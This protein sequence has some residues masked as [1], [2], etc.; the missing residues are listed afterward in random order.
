MGKSDRGDVHI[1][2]P[3]AKIGELLKI[4]N[5]TSDSDIAFVATGSMARTAQKIAQN[6]FPQ[7]SV[8]SVP[9]IKPVN[10]QQVIQLCQENKTLVVFEEHSILAGLGSLIA[11]IA[12]EF[13]PTK[14]L[15]IGT[16]DRFSHFCGTYE[17]LLKEHELDETSITRK[18]HSYL[19]NSQ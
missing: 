2:K 6:Y 10:V 16:N 5:G 15:R 18:L 1:T 19:A 11:E 14:V 4:R 13:S 7:T 17:Y 3:T 9:F 12:A 8:W